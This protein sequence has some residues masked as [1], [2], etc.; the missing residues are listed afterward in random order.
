MDLAQRYSYVFP[1]LHLVNSLCGLGPLVEMGAGT[2]Y[3]ARERRVRGADVLAFD[4]EALLRNAIWAL[5]DKGPLYYL[6][7]DTEPAKT[8]GKG[9][10]RSARA[11]TW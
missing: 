6:A 3:W 7:D 11:G 1:D 2:G 4:Q 8:T 5:Q 10:R 9:L